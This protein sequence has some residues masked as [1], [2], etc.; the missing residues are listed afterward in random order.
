MPPKT[1]IEGSSSLVKLNPKL[2][3]SF[4]QLPKAAITD[5]SN[6]DWDT[7]LS[8]SGERASIMNILVTLPEII[9]AKDQLNISEA[10]LQAL[11]ASSRPKGKFFTDAKYPIT[12]NISETNNRLS[13]VNNR[14]LDGRFVV[15]VEIYDFGLL[16]DQKQAETYRKLSKRLELEEKLEQA[17]FEL[18]SLEVITLVMSSYWKKSI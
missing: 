12:K 10:E 11:I 15:E 1:Q 14:Y 16:D 3:R 18:L 6:F 2:T 8:E 17:M 13:N 4:S 9:E 5:D 7:V